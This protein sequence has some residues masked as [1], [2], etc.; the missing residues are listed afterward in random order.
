M[1]V[2][3]TS[4]N[5]VKLAATKAA[6]QQAF[7]DKAMTFA[8]CSVPSDVA[9]QPMS[10]EETRRG[11]FNRVNNAKSL[12]PEADFWVGLEGGAEQGQAHTMTFAWMA[13]AHK[14]GQS[15]E[16]R[17]GS[18]PLPPAVSDLMA[19]GWELGKANDHVFNT[20]NSKQ[21]GGAIGLLTK[22]QFTRESVY[23]QAML[24]A[25]LPFSHELYPSH[26]SRL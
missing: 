15:S 9:E 19:S 23:T 3:I 11:A 24:F 17:S 20:H 12:H 5:P 22:G 8:S 14:S 2:V 7:P 21:A 4:K 10:D 13:I 1:L 26:L 18:I 25:L 16:S 6:F